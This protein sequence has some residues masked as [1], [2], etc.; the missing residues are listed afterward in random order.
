[1][2]AVMQMISLAPSSVSPLVA[3][4]WISR[5]AAL[6]PPHLHHFTSQALRWRV[7]RG[8]VERK[9]VVGGGGGEGGGGG[10]RGRIRNATL[11]QSN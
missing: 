5:A 9:Q 6:A 8:W 4:D 7:G 3:D 1:M 11:L 10:K 2:D